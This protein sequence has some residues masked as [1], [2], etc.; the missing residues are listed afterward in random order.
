MARKTPGLNTAS[1]ADIAF[2]LLTFFL[3]TSSINTEQGIPRRLPPPKDPN[4]K[5]EQVDINKRNVLTVRVNFNDAI[6]V[7]S[8]IIN[9][10][11]LKD[12][13]KNFLANPTNDPDLPMKESKDIEGIG[14][15]AVS[16]G[17]ISLTNDQSTT[18]NMYVQVQNE[19]QRAI[20][21][22]RDQTSMNYFG[23]KYDNLDTALQKSIQK[24]IPA[25]ISEAKSKDY[26][27]N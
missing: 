14:D 3:L 27:G 17:V 21:E 24:A 26:G 5:E 11:E 1:S 22:L 8:E 15:F 16:K 18:Y 19:L 25:N 6:M 9:I 10:N 12:V 4:V 7:N 20:N 2:L 23:K 13:A